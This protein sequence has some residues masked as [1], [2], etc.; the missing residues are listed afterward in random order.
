MRNLI[1]AIEQI[2]LGARAV[3]TGFQSLWHCV[4]RV[5]VTKRAATVSIQNYCSLHAFLSVVKERVG[6]RCHLTPQA[7]NFPRTF[8][9]GSR[10]FSIAGGGGR[11]TMSTYAQPASAL[12]IRYRT[13]DNAPL[14]H[15]LC[16]HSASPPSSLQRT[17]R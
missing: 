11:R 8:S 13:R 1:D 6:C 3:R 2:A 10:L 5:A 9:T 7:S 12:R 17:S 16:F 15:C 14:I 4:T